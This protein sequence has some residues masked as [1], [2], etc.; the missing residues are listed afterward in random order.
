[1]ARLLAALP[2][3]RRAVVAGDLNTAALPDPRAEP[4]LGWFEHPEARE[5]LFAAMRDAGFD[6]RRCNAPDQT[7]RA[8]PDGRPAP[9][10]KRIDWFFTRGVEA[11]HPRTW[12]AVDD[13]G[14]PL[15]D[16]E[17]ITVD[18]G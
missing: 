14:A 17:M 10:V 3:E 6:W 4:D 7:R 2:S 16:H 13:G 18:I 15:S 5:P 8:I 11:S 12:A 9:L 1:M